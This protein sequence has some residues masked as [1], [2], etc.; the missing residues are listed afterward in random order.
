[1]VQPRLIPVLL[2]K[3]SGLVKTQ[4]FC[5]P[6]YLGD[7]MNIIKIFNEKE[8]DEMVFLDILASKE[9]KRPSLERIKNIA[10]ECFMPLCFGGGIS[11]AGFAREVLKIGV[12]KISL[13]TSAVTKPEL[14]T[15]CANMFGSSSVVVSIDVKV[16]MWGKQLVYIKGGTQKTK[17]S[18]IELAIEAE[19]RG[20][21]EIL[22]NSI[23]RDGMMAGYDVALLKQVSEAV[24]VPVIGCG[25]AGADEHFLE[26]L[27][28]TKVK[29]LAAGSYFVFKGKHRAVLISYPDQAKIKHWFT[30]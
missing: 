27:K 29:A 23:D 10:S 30:N 13:N 11:D 28:T 18:P 9:G 3:G 19:K 14:I 21:G 26:V 20:A 2:L 6:K 15:E 12:E 1:M 4:K 7:P 5:D 25:G 24:N 8:V 22:I 16:N 17:L